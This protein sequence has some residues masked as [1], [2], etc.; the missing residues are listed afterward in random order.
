VIA[1]DGQSA[2]AVAYREA[3]VEIASRS[4]AQSKEK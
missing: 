2:G 1:Y 4:A 3:A